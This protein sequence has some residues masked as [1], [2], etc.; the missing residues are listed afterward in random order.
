MDT[1]SRRQISISQWRIDSREIRPISQ[2]QLIAEIKGIH[3]GFVEV[4]TECRK[5]VNDA[6]S[7]SMLNNLQWQALAIMHIT[8]IAKHH[9]FLLA[10]QQSSA[11]PALRFLPYKYSMPA[12]MW[13]YG[14]YSF[15]ELLYRHLPASF[16]HMLSFLYLAYTMLGYLS[17]RVLA[18]KHVWIEFMGDLGRYHMIIAE[19]SIDGDMWA[20]ISR[21]R[22][23]EA[24]NISP[25]TGRLYHRL[26]ILAKQNMLQELHYYAKSLCVVEPFVA[27]RES[28]LKLFVFV[29]TQ[30]DQRNYQLPAFD[31]AFIKVYNSLFTNNCTNRFDTILDGF[32]VLLDNQLGQVT[33]KFLEQGYQISI[34]NSIAVLAFCSKENPV[35]K[36]IALFEANKSYAQSE[37]TEDDSSHSMTLL[38]RAE[39]LSNSTLD[40]ILQRVGDPNCLSYVHCTLVFIYRISNVSGAI[41]LLAEAFPWPRLMIY[42]NTLLRSNINL[43]RIRADEFPWLPVLERGEMHPLPEDYAMRGLGFAESLYPKEWFLDDKR[44]EEVKYHELRIMEEHRKERILWLACR[45]CDAGSWIRFDS[46]RP[47]FTVDDN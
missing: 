8:L 32:L 28:I 21:S 7:R 47:G 6:S 17:E 23:L 15:L 9:D 1:S 3:A 12:R 13:L 16:D 27:T 34:S 40:I 5:M 38:R 30:N 11:S 33:R 39:K 45:I 36:A 26:A 24:S 2:Q 10:S 44:E 43:D 35:M 19:D 41:N 29:N 25:I 31:V 20:E 18:S 4:E 46:S 14:I 22:Y 42:L 37:S